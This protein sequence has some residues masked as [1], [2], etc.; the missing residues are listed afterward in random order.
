MA[1]TVTTL[2]FMKASQV[3]RIHRR[4]VSSPGMK[5]LR[6]FYSSRSDLAPTLRG[7]LICYRDDLPTTQVYLP[8]ADTE[9]DD[10]LNSLMTR[11]TIEID[12]TKHMPYS[13][14]LRYRIAS[15]VYQGVSISGRQVTGIGST[16]LT[17]VWPGCYLEYNNTLYRVS[18][19]VSDV[20]LYLE[21]SPGASVSE[22]SLPFYQVHDNQKA[23]WPMHAEM[24]GLAFLYNA[25]KPIKL[26]STDIKRNCGP[27]ILTV[28]TFEE[29]P[30][31]NDVSSPTTFGGIIYAS[32]YATTTAS[33]LGK[34]TSGTHSYVYT[35]VDSG[36]ETVPTTASVVVTTSTATDGMVN[37]T[38][39]AL[40]SG[41]IGANIYR[42]FSGNTGDYKLVNPTPVLAGIYTDN[43]VD[44]D[45]GASAPSSN[46]TTTPL[47]DPTAA[48]TVV[49]TKGGTTQY[50][51]G[52]SSGMV[53]W[54]NPAATGESAYLRVNDDVRGIDSYDDAG[55]GFCVLVT[56]STIVYTQQSTGLAVPSGFKAHTLGTGTAYRG[57][58][59]GVTAG[60]AK[61]A[62]V[63]GLG[64]EI[65]TIDTF[66]APQFTEQTSGTSEDLLG[67]CYASTL[68][69]WVAVGTAGTVLTSTDGA[70]WNA[71]TSGTSEDLTAVC[72]NGTCFTGVGT[73]G[74]VLTSSNGTA[75]TTVTTTSTVDLE[76][77]F[78]HGTMIY[79]VGKT[80]QL[81][82]SP[83][84]WLSESES[85]MSTRDFYT[86]TGTPDG[87]ASAI[88]GG[89]QFLAAL[90]ASAATS[91]YTIDTRG[92]DFG[93]GTMLWA[94]TKALATSGSLWVAL[95]AIEPYAY[96]VLLSPQLLGPLPGGGWTYV[97]G[98]G[99]VYSGTF[100]YNNALTDVF[101]DGTTFMVSG[102][103]T[104]EGTPVIVEAVVYTVSADGLTITKR[105]SGI[106]GETG[107]A[108]FNTVFGTSSLAIAAGKTDASKC[109]H[110]TSADHGATWTP[111]TVPADYPDLA[112]QINAGCI[113][114]DVAGG[115]TY[116]LEVGDAGVIIRSSDG[117]IAPWAQVTSGVTATLEKI[118]TQPGTP[119]VVA[120][121]R[122]LSPFASVVLW[123][124]DGGATW[125]LANTFYD[126]WLKGICYDTVAGKWFAVDTSGNVYTSADMTSFALD[127]NITPLGFVT[128]MAFLKNS[129][130]YFG[131][132]S[133]ATITGAP[134]SVFSTSSSTLTYRKVRQVNGCFYD[135]AGGSVVLAC[136]DAVVV[137][138]DSNPVALSFAAGDMKWNAVT[139]SNGR[140]VIVGDGG[141]V[142]YSDDGINWSSGSISSSADLLAVCWSG[143][144][145]FVVGTGG[146]AQ[147]SSDGATWAPLSAGTTLD[148][149]GVAYDVTSSTLQVIGALDTSTGGTNE[150]I[151][152][153]STDD[154]ANWT[155][156]DT[157]A[158]AG[159][160]L[161]GLATDGKSNFICI[162]EKGEVGVIDS[163]IDPTVWSLPNPDGV[164]GDGFRVIIY[165]PLLGR[166]VIAGD[167]GTAYESSNL[168]TDWTAINLGASGTVTALYTRSHTDAMSGITTVYLVD[169]WNGGSSAYWT[170]YV[171]SAITGTFHPISTSYRA[172]AFA[173]LDGAVILG[174]CS[175]LEA[176][177]TTGRSIWNH[178]PR[179]LRWTS[180]GTLDDFMSYGANFADLN[181]SGQILDMRALQHMLVIFESNC[182]SALTSTGD[183]SDPYEYRVLAQGITTVSNPIVVGDNVYFIDGAGLLMACNGVQVTSAAAAFDLSEYVDF[184]PDTAVVQLV[185]NPD[186]KVIM[187]YQMDATNPVFYA[188]DPEL[189]TVASWHLP[190]CA[191]GNYPRMIVN[192]A[193]GEII[194]RPGQVPPAD[195][196]GGASDAGGAVSSN[197]G[198]CVEPP[199]DLSVLVTASDYY[200][201]PRDTISIDVAITNNGSRSVPGTTSVLLLM[202]TEKAGQPTIPATYITLELGS[203][204]SSGSKQDGEAQAVMTGAI[205]AGDT[206]HFGVNVE[207]Y[208]FG[209]T[210]TPV[211]NVTF[212][213]TVVS[214]GGQ[215]FTDDVVVDFREPV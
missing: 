145:F 88:I 59:I 68:T 57:V 80:G 192:V 108:I 109:I 83:D 146:E 9:R 153:Y 35:F 89:D 203:D 46:T 138:T 116:G 64:G 28:D 5:L 169:Y 56:D 93:G 179:R 131:G 39:P 176:D 199:A 96:T 50:L 6:N 123:S 74:V 87:T 200:V 202:V 194:P 188:V 122:N 214:A 174:G 14:D 130:Y 75:W 21:D 162:G 36:G 189:G 18:S 191:V 66:D 185:W 136:S 67:V 44:G 79:A 45:L 210:P 114:N 112:G 99:S 81:V 62:I 1:R 137:G 25:T 72:W 151:S 213:A 4:D 105:S 211:S 38:I 86:G 104:H 150:P 106:Q 178:Y 141:A 71:Q 159:C 134:S 29:E 206:V 208:P 205:A 63:V 160:D 73:G 183:P 34:V 12:L 158:L 23:K 113:V 55:T 19:V 184:T 40:P 121:G 195:P 201:N 119:N 111:V 48:P 13:A 10:F 163:S 125:T 171:G 209:A 47:D 212:T 215:T 31:S 207:N 129:K 53:F 120:I 117:I 77:V 168:G 196:F 133:S 42:I 2:T 43:I 41:A 98:T 3:G 52:G 76:G 17:N 69:M 107:R 187:V 154:G 11:G 197:L 84:N 101:W 132:P 26:S 60:A 165:D 198:T 149:R 8:V 95:D 152:L 148:F 54:F 103:D 92:G 128:G 147:Y 126:I 161:T 164:G 175:E 58:A 167:A 61:L 82:A 143:S 166:W 139:K 110:A 33:A 78:R 32:K 127:V 90:T 177:T 27:F 135:A 16:F 85:V 65:Y 155:A 144:Y 91:T 100:V 24:Q 70:T 204:F 51:L 94:S 30:A 142:G 20:L 7:D 140:W 22:L 186:L 181:G 157:T 115:H 102:Q 193:T 172:Q 180:P 156:N 190:V 15:K 49:V 118:A 124:D 97:L 170:N 173:L 182:I 37:I